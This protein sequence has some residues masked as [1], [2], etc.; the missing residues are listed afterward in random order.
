MIYPKSSLLQ[1]QTREQSVAKSIFPRRWDSGITSST[2]TKI[3]APAAKLNK[4]GKKG[5]A[6]YTKAAP[7]TPAAGSTAAE[8]W[9]YQKLLGAE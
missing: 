7:I 6:R 5:W 2:T 4:Y 1:S 8:S 9:P 3:I